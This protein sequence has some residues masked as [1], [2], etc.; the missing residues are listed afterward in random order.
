[1]V[2]SWNPEG[3]FMAGIPV[4]DTR[5]DAG[6]TDTAP[7]SNRPMTVDEFYAFT[8]TRPDGEKWE[9][10]EGEPVLNAS[11]SPIH[12]MIAMNVAVALKIREREIKAPW[13]AMLPLGVRVSE[14]DRPEPDVLVF[15]SDHR[16]PDTRRDRDDVIVVF[17][18]L[19]PSTEK[20][21]LGWKRKAYAS[22][23][24]LTHYIA[25]SQDAVD[26]VVFAR[27]DAF[28]RRRHQS[29]DE[30]IDLR[31]LGVSLPVAEIYRDTGLT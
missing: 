25:I 12:Q 17:E 3:A 11:P 29:L 28:E 19:S 31:S 26:V 14:K 27:D 10:I 23:A 16:R 20:R 22:L 30:A 5:L 15:P 24:S 2:E 9:L 6:P 8:D 4:I 13:T 21:D 1:L 18:V 7:W